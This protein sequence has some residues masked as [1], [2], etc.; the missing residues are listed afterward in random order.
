MERLIHCSLVIFGTGESLKRVLCQD[1]RSTKS[2]TVTIRSRDV[3]TVSFV[4]ANL[5]D[6]ITFAYRLMCS[7]QIESS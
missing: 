7:L 3:A 2:L 4:G 5:G 1:V 6:R